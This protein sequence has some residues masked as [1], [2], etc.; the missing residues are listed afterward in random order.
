MPTSTNVRCRA[1]PGPRAPR[2]CAPPTAGSIP[3]RPPR[4]RR[5]PTW[6]WRSARR[7]RRRAPASPTSRGWRRARSTPKRRPGCCRRSRCAASRRPPSASPT[8]PRADVGGATVVV[9]G[10]AWATPL[11]GRVLAE[12]GARVVRIEHPGRPDPFPLHDRLA[13]GQERHGLDLGVGPRPRRARRVARACRPARRRP[14]TPGARERGVRRRRAPIRAPAPLDPAGGRLRRRR[15]SRLRT[16]GGGAR[17]LGGPPRS[18]A[19]GAFVGRRSG[20]RAARRV[21]RGRA[22]HRGVRPVRGPACPSR[23]RSVICSS[24]SA[25]VPD[26]RLRVARVDGVVEIVF[27]HPPINIYDVATRDALCEVL[28]AVIAD[29]DVRV[30]LFTA[31]GDHFSAGADLQG[32]RYG[33][34]GV[35]DARRPMG[36]RRVGPAPRGPGPDGGVDAGQRGR[37]RLRAR[38]AVRRAARGRRLRGRVARGAGGHAPRRGREPDVAPRRGHECGAH[39]RDHRR[40]GARRRRAGARLRRRSGA[41]AQLRARTD[42]LVARLA[43]RPTAAVRAAKAAVWAALDLPLEV[44]L[45]READLAATLRVRG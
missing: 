44:G 14:P 16:R 21:D 41:R 5:S 4:G 1:A 24:G 36:S 30:V 43:A 45:A 28:T 29:P 22:A 10:T 15:P 42:E 32:V 12:L 19:A 17:R 37:L 38:V 20:R 23:A 39:G 8:S 9:L 6:R 18:A 33:P 3:A 40:A 11:V 13:A 27:D 2:C 7:S 26:E 31:T 35:R 25:P 34:V